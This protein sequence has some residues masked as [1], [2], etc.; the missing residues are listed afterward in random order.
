VNEQLRLSV[1]VCIARFC[2]TLKSKYFTILVVLF[3]SLFSQVI[4]EILICLRAL[5]WGSSVKHNPQRV[6]KEHNLQD[7]DVVQIIKKL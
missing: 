2:L 1:T 4:N 6:G 7:E 3:L 5:V